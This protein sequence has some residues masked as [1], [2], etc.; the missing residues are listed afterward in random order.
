MSIRIAGSGCYIPTRTVTN[1]DFAKHVFLND[2]GTP[3]N[4]SNEVVTEKFRQ[5]TGIEERRYAED[6]LL[7]SDIGF[8]AAEIPIN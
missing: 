6:D 3:L 7:T 8:F 4:Y 1:A 5:I 2:N